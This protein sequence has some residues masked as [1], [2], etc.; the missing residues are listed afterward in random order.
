MAD[1]PLEFVDV[2]RMLKR[3]INKGGKLYSA[4]SPASP[5]R[6]ALTPASAAPRR[7]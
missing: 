7:G 4:C 1:A 6:H 3:A 2:L 5:V